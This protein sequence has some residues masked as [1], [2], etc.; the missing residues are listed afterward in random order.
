MET[1]KAIALRKSVRNFRKDQISEECLNSILSAGCLAPVGRK[2][3]DTIHFTVVQNKEILRK[4]T[5][6][7]KKHFNTDMDVIYDVPTLVIITSQEIPETPNIKYA[8]VSC[9]AE[10]MLLAATDQDVASV[11]LWM[12]AVAIQKNEDLKRKLG[13]PEGY[14]P[15]IAVGLGYSTEIIS[16]E[17]DLKITIS[18]NRI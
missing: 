18:I 10:N 7:S 9:I 3:Y 16:K 6:I 15:I 8:N 14:E 2:R 12:P 13:I 1:L 4:I 11:Y 17:R 5:D